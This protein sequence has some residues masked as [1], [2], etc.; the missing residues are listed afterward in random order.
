MSG[1]QDEAERLA[2]V[3]L[4]EARAAAE[5]IAPDRW[6]RVDGEMLGWVSARRFEAVA[7][8]LLERFGLDVIFG[9]SI[10]AGLTMQTV[11]SWSWDGWVSAPTRVDVQTQA[12]MSPSS[13]AVTTGRRIY[14]R[15]LLRLRVADDAE[16]DLCRA[17]DRARPAVREEVERLLKAY[18]RREKIAEDRALRALLGLVGDHEWSVTHLPTYQIACLWMRLVGQLGTG[19]SEVYEPGSSPLMRRGD[20]LPEGMQ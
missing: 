18:C 20:E 10:L 5:P 9:G 7:D 4:G 13:A 16:T 3:A 14:T 2:R 12:G 8:E 11:W 6:D 19:A 15:Q 1:R 17:H